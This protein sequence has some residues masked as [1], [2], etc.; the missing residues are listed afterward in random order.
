[1]THFFIHT[2]SFLQIFLNSAVVV[3][4][5]HPYQAGLLMRYSGATGLCGGSVISATVVLTA[6]HC[7]LNS[8]STQV[9][10]GAHQIT[11]NEANQQRRTV[12]PSGYR[13][14]AGYNPSNL[15]N[16]IGILILA[17]PVTAN[18][19]VRWSVLPALGNSETFAGELATVTGWGRTSDTVP[20]TSPQLRSVQ[21]NIITNAA[22]IS[23]LGAVVIV[24]STICLAT[25]GG[26]GTCSG[27]SGGP[28][29]VAR[30]GNR[31][32]VGVVS[33]GVGAG[34]ERGFPAGFARV[35]SF[36]Q[37]IINNSS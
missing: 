32:Q 17:T 11:A 22:C 8:L 27:D 29:T 19:F 12:Q 37:W 1:M 23:S 21:N 5:A 14:H 6:A 34:C 26:R 18:Q 36:R 31:L 20:G 7:P 9:I 33:F 15:N 30:G 13:L 10:L 25:T 4:H 28:L 24:P 3:P 2:N 16:D 35:T